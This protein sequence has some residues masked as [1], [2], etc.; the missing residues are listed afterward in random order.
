MITTIQELKAAN[1]TI[2]AMTS[3]VSTLKANLQS[4]ANSAA[5]ALIAKDVEIATLSETVATT[6]NQIKELGAKLA[7]AEA[8]PVEIMA[9]LGVPPVAVTGAKTEPTTK[10]DLWAEYAK[11]TDPKA[12]VIFYRAHKELHP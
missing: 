7:A 3:Q 12:R 1:E 8:K 9:A 4:E 6:Q 5:D 10:A 2:Q 11:I